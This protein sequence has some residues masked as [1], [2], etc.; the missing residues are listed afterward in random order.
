M[1]LSVVGGGTKSP[2]HSRTHLPAG[3]AEPE[4]RVPPYSAAEGLDSEQNGQPF[5]NISRVSLKIPKEGP[6]RCSSVRAR[7]RNVCD[8]DHYPSPAPYNP[9][10]PT[11]PRS[12]PPLGTY[13]LKKFNCPPLLHR[14][15]EEGDSDSES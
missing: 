3:S 5:C 1:L 10:P 6:S 11:S 8:S 13:V 2:G 7:V 9:R 15:R 4:N 12:V 14:S